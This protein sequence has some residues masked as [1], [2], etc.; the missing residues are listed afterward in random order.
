MDSYSVYMHTSPSEKVYIG[1]TKVK[2]TRRWGRGSRYKQHPHFYAAI[3]KYGWDQIK[4]EVLFTNLTKEQACEKERELIDRY[5]ATDRRFG[6]NDKSGG[7]IGVELTDDVRK[8]ISDSLR[9]HYNN[10]PEDRIKISNRMKGR[11]VSEETRRKLSEAHSGIHFVMRDD[12][13]DNIGSANKRRMEEDRELYLST[14]NRCRENGRRYSK[15]VVL[16]DTDGNDVRSYASC[17]EAERAT[18]IKGS[19]ISMCCKGIRKTAGGFKWRF[20]T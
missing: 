17:R 13:K 15:P 8:N 4:H 12:W 2:P 10:H 20:A 14:C 6:Y 9:T 3:Q 11:Q 16:L 18:G 19:N 5:K 1:I 7:E